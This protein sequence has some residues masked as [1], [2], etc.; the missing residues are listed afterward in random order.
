MSNLKEKLKEIVGDE[1]SKGA[2]KTH[3]RKNNP[4]LKE[5]SSQI[6]RRILHAI[7]AD[8]N[9]NQSKLAETLS[10]TPQQISKIVKGQENMTL[11]TIYKLSKALNVELISFPEYEYSR[12]PETPIHYFVQFNNWENESEVQ[13][14]VYHQSIE[15]KGI[16]N[17]TK[18]TQL[19][20]S[21]EYINR[22]DTL[23][24]EG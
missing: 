22:L 11:E 9:M 24:N 17:D 2:E 1:I 4:W 15:Y 3:F 13:K 14:L 23:D 8:K 5:Y 6:A 21:K 16:S 18:Y 7:G 20:L 10:V 12:V 19:K